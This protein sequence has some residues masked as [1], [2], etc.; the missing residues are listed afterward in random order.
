MD[1][2]TY[3]H[4]GTAMLFICML[5]AGRSGSHPHLTTFTSSRTKLIPRQVRRT[6]THQ[7]PCA[8]TDEWLTIRFPQDKRIKKPKPKKKKKKQKTQKKKK[9]NNQKKKTNQKQKKKKK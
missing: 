9:K 8:R 7:I 4:L 3:S 2:S 5:D 1:H 6:A